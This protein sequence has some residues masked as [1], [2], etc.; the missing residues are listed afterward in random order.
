MAFR[1]VTILR[2]WLSGV[3]KKR[4]AQQPGFDVKTVRRYLAARTS[5]RRGDRGD[6]AGPR[7]AAR[8]RGGVPSTVLAAEPRPGAVCRRGAQAQTPAH[9]RVCRSRARTTPTSTIVIVARDRH[10]ACRPAPYFGTC[11]SAAVRLC[12]VEGTPPRPPNVAVRGAAGSRA[13]TVRR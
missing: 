3:P 10:T 13:R 6:A 1:E 9:A 2:L 12:A 5:P 4:I 7:P 8:G 11:P